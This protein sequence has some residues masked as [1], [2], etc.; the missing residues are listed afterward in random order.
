MAE[1]MRAD[2]MQS[3]QVAM[4]VSVAHSCSIV[5]CISC[6][7]TQD[8]LTTQLQLIV[9][10]STPK[11]L[12]SRDREG[13]LGLGLWVSVASVCMMVCVVVQVA[14]MVMMREHRLLPRRGEQELMTNFV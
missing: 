1:R 2:V 11:V 13:Q 9:E 7:H 8:Y 12:R 3:I 4:S 5:T 6:P 14:K 10:S